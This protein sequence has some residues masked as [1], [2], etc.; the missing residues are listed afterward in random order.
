M[1]YMIGT[2]FFAQHNMDVEYPTAGI[3]HTAIWFIEGMLL[4]P[5]MLSY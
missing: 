3:G 5:S 4:H 2:E 1:Y